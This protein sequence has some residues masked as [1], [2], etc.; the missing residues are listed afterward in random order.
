VCGVG[1]SLPSRRKNLASV[2]RGKRPQQAEQAYAIKRPPTIRRLRFPRA[3]AH[4]PNAK[5]I[6][7][8]SYS[9]PSTIQSGLVETPH[10]DS[11]LTVCE[12]GL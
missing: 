1:E 6:M 12:M 4:T 11:S 7:S 10:A 8:R 2:H 3:D 5:A 9:A